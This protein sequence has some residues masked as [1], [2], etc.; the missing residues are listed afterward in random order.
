M[1]LSK[2]TNP[3][4]R[5][6]W[7]NAEFPILCQ[8]CLGEN[9]YI[10]M[11]K[12][13]YGKECKIC[14]RP[15]T[16]FRWC[17]GPKARYKKT[18]IC[19]T[20][21]K[22]KNVCQTCLLDLEYGLPVQVRD[23]AMNLTDQMPSSDVNKEYWTQNMERKLAESDGTRPIGELGKAQ[24]PSDL[25]VRMTRSQPYY[26]RNRPH[27]CSFWVKGECKRGEECP[28]RHEMP[29]DPNDPLANQNIADR[30]HGVND[31]VAEKLLK[32]AKALP[33]LDAPQDKTVT[34]LFVGGLTDGIT[35]K[36]LADNFYQY[37][38]IRSITVVPKQNCAFVT[39]TTRQAAEAAADGTFN[40]LV[41]KQQRLKILWGKAQG[42]AP[43]SGDGAG[44]NKLPPVAGLPP[45][46]PPPPMASGVPPPPPP[47]FPP[48]MQPPPPQPNMPGPKGIHYPSQDPRR[49]GT[50]REST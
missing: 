41:I 31:P 50:F 34:S 5:Q 3:Y 48:G 24:P 6:H 35:E 11:M 43:V 29:T 32:R 8:T 4:N 47:P 15:F 30:Y 9:P 20:C 28:Y 17:P 33:T 23:T 27:I 42:Q 2:S 36:D 18:E 39:F 7:E 12:E 37:G 44:S 22:I 19:Q 13:K 14:A 45:P 10:R 38:E 49:M 26:K 25:L 40:K 1:A 46:L 16:V 21:A